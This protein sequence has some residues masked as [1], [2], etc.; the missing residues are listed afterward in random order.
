MRALSQIKRF[1][2]M[3]WLFAGKNDMF[4]FEKCLLLACMSRFQNWLR[5]CQSCYG[6]DKN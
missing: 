6:V 3:E 5:V 4:V 2:L 1:V